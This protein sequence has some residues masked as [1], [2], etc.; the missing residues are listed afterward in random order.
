MSGLDRK[1]DI[2]NRG[3]A[4]LDLNQINNK[5]TVSLTFGLVNFQPFSLRVQTC[6][7]SSV[8]QVWERKAQNTH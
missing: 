7:I 4:Q 3:Q 5:A 2:V 1:T 8:K 6:S